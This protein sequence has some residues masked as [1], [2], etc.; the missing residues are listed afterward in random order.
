MRNRKPRVFYL[1]AGVEHRCHF[2]TVY[3]VS[4]E[5]TPN[6]PPILP[7]CAPSHVEQ[8]VIVLCQKVSVTII[9][10]QMAAR[11]MHMTCWGEIKCGLTI[12]VTKI[13]TIFILEA[14]TSFARTV[15]NLFIMLSTHGWPSISGE[16]IKCRRKLNTYLRR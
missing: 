15:S 13:I 4:L 1:G 12:S 7:V 5:V 11:A 10:L 9:E 2:H 6:A 16:K 3:A 14:T 8:M